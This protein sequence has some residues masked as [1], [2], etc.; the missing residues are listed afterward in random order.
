MRASR[1]CHALGLRLDDELASLVREQAPNLAAAAAERVM[2]EMCLTLACGRASAAVRLGLGLARRW[3]CQSWRRVMT[4]C[5][6]GAQRWRGAAAMLGG[7]PPHWRCSTVWTRCWSSLSRR[8]RR[9]Q[10]F[11]RDRWADPVDGAVTRP[12]ALRL[13][14]L[15]GSLDPGQVR[16]VGQ[17]LKLSSTL[18]SL[19]VTVARCAR[20][21]GFAGLAARRGAGWPRSGARSAGCTVGTGGGAA[22][23][24]RPRRRGFRRAGTSHD[25]PRRPSVHRAVL[26]RVL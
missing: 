7:R 12:V 8:F 4:G 22:D 2:N 26:L 10:A 15:A 18:A 16:T 1:F 24:C 20:V 9:R 21:E 5:P 19:L 6:R 25:G 3:C 23:A 11:S 17:R 13:A 14:G